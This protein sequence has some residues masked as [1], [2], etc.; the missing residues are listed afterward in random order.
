M[1]ILDNEGHDPQGLGNT[2]AIDIIDRLTFDAARCQAQ[3]S[4]GIAGN[5]NEA[6]AEIKRLR[7]EVAILERDLEVECGRGCT[8]T[9]GTP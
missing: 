8:V 3:Y 4:K 5:I 7:A 6:I 2:P 9:K 1:S